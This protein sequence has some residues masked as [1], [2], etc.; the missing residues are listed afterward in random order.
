[1][2]S[3]STSTSRSRS[4]RRVESQTPPRQV[5][6]SSCGQLIEVGQVI[7]WTDGRYR[8]S[9]CSGEGYDKFIEF[10]RKQRADEEEAASAT[11]DEGWSRVQALAAV[12]QGEHQG[13]PLGERAAHEPEFL[14][15]QRA[16]EAE[17]AANEAKKAEAKA[18][19]KAS[20]RG[21]EGRRREEGRPSVRQ[22]AGVE[23]SANEQAASAN[24]QAIRHALR[25]VSLLP[26]H[27][28]EKVHK[29]EPPAELFHE[30]PEGV[31]EYIGASL[32]RIRFEDPREF[33][34]AVV[35]WNEWYECRVKMSKKAKKAEEAKKA[36]DAKKADEAFENWELAE[37]LE[38]D[39]AFEDHGEV[40]AQRR[41]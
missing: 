40:Q 10:L 33:T 1:M 15:K 41:A 21:E 39:E 24:Q 37:A 31:K 16:D 17:K 5:R 6:C 14:R 23:A 9:D 2:F 20:Q 34:R 11:A 8:H 26:S 32:D 27:P 25:Q 19:A 4:P 3:S 18:K 30:L 13:G 29:K 36:A 28:F 35:F 22:P 38:A 7:E 12:G